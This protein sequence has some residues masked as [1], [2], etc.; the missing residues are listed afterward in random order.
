MNEETEPSEEIAKSFYNN[1]TMTLRQI[2]LKKLKTGTTNFSGKSKTDYWVRETM[3]RFD[4]IP[5]FILETLLA[6][7]GRKNI[8]GPKGCS[9]FY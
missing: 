5:E 4:C 9:T 7:K 6:Y 2:I 8:P 3:D 1:I